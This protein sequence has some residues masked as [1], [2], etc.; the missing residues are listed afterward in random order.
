MPNDEARLEAAKVAVID[1]AP[2]DNRHTIEQM[3]T[4]LVG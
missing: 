1:A 3:F 2:A 4:T